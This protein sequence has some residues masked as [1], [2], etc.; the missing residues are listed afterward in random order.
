MSAVNQR[1]MAWGGIVSMVILLIGM[2]VMAGF[3][4]PPGPNKSMQEIVQIYVDRNTR[5]KFG[6]IVA[7]AGVTLLAPWSAALSIQ[8]RRIEGELAPLALSQA[9]LGVMLL[10]EFYIPC[11]MWEA[12]AFRPKIDP[13]FTYRIHDLA[14]IMFIALPWTGMLQAILLGVAI[15]QD[16]RE[17]PV[18]PRWVAYLSFWSALCFLPGGLNCLAKT[19]VLAWNGLLAWWLGL[20]IFGGWIFAISVCLVK[21]AIPHQE[22]EEA[23]RTS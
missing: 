17:T 8:M 14:S 3:V 20:A 11:I 1:W 10:V 4:P 15:L 13:G 7:G 21:Y 5:I 2:W 16:R 6:I 9:L 23:Q 18:F 12:A 19:G 22:A